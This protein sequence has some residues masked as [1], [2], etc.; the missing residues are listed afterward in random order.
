MRYA[1]TLVIVAMLAVMTAA[2][3]DEPPVT[4]PDDGADATATAVS[5]GEE[6]L[7]GL[8]CLV[9]LAKMQAYDSGWTMV[10]TQKIPNGD[11]CC[12]IAVR[13]LVSAQDAE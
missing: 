12:E 9:D 1:R 2:T 11:E 8:Y 6:D 3:C 13:P 7:G 5:P 4:P 10:H